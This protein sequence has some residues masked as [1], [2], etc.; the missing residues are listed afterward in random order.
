VVGY[1]RMGALGLKTGA[2]GTVQFDEFESR[3]T[4]YVGPLP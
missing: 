1:V 3:R 4:T 2:H